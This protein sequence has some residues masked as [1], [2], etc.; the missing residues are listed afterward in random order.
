MSPASRGRSSGGRQRG[1][2]MEGKKECEC[3][4]IHPDAGGS[5]QEAAAT[6]I[7]IKMAS[8][9]LC[10]GNLWAMRAF[11]VKD[12]KG[13][14]RSGSG[15]LFCCGATVHC[16][17]RETEWGEGR[18]GKDFGVKCLS[19]RCSGRAGNKARRIQLTERKEK[20]G[21]YRTWWSMVC[22]RRYLVVLG[23]VV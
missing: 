3:E 16:R 11:A 13:P 17:E 14:R 7:R 2:Y 22:T 8:R 10:R 4:R 9:R 23:C 5:G 21:T 18:A 19:G 1:I 6:A 15:R 20:K 12:A